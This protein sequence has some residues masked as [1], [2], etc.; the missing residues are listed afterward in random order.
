MAA[1]PS[2][3]DYDYLFKASFAR[4]AHATRTRTAAFCRHCAERA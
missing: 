1:A 3:D 4:A 2:D